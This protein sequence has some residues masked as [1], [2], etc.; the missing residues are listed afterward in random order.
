[1]VIKV[2]FR[3]GLSHLFDTKEGKLTAEAEMIKP[4]PGKK[5]V[6]WDERK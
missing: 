2:D 4:Q 1:M 5:A 6:V 3:S